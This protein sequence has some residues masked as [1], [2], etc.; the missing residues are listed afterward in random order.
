M[1]S[2]Y[3]FGIAGVLYFFATYWREHSV[4]KEGTTRPNRLTSLLM[5][6]AICGTVAAV[7]LPMVDMVVLVS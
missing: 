1:I 4:P 5:A 6:E 7:A 2:V 3:L